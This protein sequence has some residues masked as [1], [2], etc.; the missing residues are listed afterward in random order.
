M[1]IYWLFLF[2][3]FVSPFMNA[4]VGID[5][6]RLSGYLAQIEEKG[7][8]MGSLDIMK[9]GKSIYSCCLG[10]DIIS[11]GQAIDAPLYRIGSISKM[12]TAVLI[13]QQVEKGKLKLDDKLSDYFPEVPRAG[14]ITIYQLLEHSAGLGNYIMKNDSSYTWMLSEVSHAEIMK[15]IIRQGILY[16]PGKG[17]KYSNSGY[18]LLARILVKIAKKPYPEIVE[19]SITR[20]LELYQTYSGLIE[21]TDIAI[22]YQMDEAGEWIEVP[23]FYFPNVMGV[24]ELVSTPGDINCFLH[25]L[26]SGKLISSE[27]LQQIMKPFGT[28]RH[29]R[30][31]MYLPYN[32]HNF[33]GHTGDTFG[34]HSIGAFNEQDG[35]SIAVN[36]NGG[37]IPFADFL[38]GVFKS[39]YK[40]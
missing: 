27:H 9:D 34:V 19:E 21:A 31:M 15:E 12:F 40:E 28:D 14:E 29:G 30:G 26:F 8:V 39:I 24:G 33:Y 7:Q 35:I 32:K 3:F 18:Y 6:L 36:M 2:L 16:D 20:P 10:K 4:Q 25:A 37:T 22:P 5:T 13:Y 1:K 11:Q 17:F 23:D 38:Q